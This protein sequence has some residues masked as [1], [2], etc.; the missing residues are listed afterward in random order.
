[1][2]DARWTLPVQLAVTEDV[3]FGLSRKPSGFGPIC[4]KLSLSEPIKERD[5]PVRVLVGLGRLRVNFHDLGLGRRSLGGRGGVEPCGGF[6]Q[7]ALFRYRGIVDGRHVEVSG[8][9]VRGDRSPC[10]CHLCQFVRGLVVFPHDVV[11]FETV[12]LVF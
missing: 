4:R 11:E 2:E 5:S 8:K 12:E 9:D 6:G 1:M 10:R 3:S 7:W